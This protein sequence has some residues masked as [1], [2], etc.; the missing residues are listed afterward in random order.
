M[1][2]PIIPNDLAS[3]EVCSNRAQGEYLKLLL[4]WRDKS[5]H[6]STDQTLGA[7]NVRPEWCPRAV[8]LGKPDVIVKE[9]R[10]AGQRPCVRSMAIF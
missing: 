6:Q 10:G 3:I 7:C 2:R 9:A 4:A 8:W 1:R 5:R